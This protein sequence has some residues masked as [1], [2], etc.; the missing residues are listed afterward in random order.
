VEN[1]LQCAHL[2]ALASLERTESRWGIWHLRSDFPE[3]D[4]KNWLKH[5]ILRQGDG[6]QDVKLYHR[7]ILKL[8]GRS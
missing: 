3:R 4:D 7:P 6:P 5:I 8:E 2:S 1:I